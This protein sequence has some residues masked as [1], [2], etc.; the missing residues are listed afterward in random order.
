MD[1]ALWIALLRDLR[2]RGGGYRES[3]A[4]LLGKLANGTRIAEAFVPYE[5]LDS[6]AQHH[7]YVRLRTEAFGNLWAEC[8]QQKREVVADVHTHPF[9]PRQSISDRENPMI[10]IAGHV[11]LIV[12]L[13][14]M[15]D[16]G[17]ADVS[18][19]LFHGRGRWTTYLGKE[20]EK[21]F[22][23]RKG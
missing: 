12:P 20:A 2:A 7:D 19:N 6:E 23:V 14:A 15:H 17:P 18:V 10:S 16:V 13:F 11:A 9:G 22:Y 3:G 1:A 21:K 8:A 5:S 4:F